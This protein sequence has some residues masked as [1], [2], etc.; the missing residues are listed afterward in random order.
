MVRKVIITTLTGLAA[1]TLAVDLWTRSSGDVL[2]LEGSARLFF[3]FCGPELLQVEFHHAPVPTVDVVKIAKINEW[4]GFGL[5]YF[6]TVPENPD[7]G[8]STTV[9]GPLWM[10]LVLFATYPLVAFARG[11]LR[12]W[13]RARRGGCRKCGYNLTGNVSGRCPECGSPSG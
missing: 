8:G 13:R 11:P 6:H 10:P 1:A 2:E 4:L 9:H 3:S 7:F 12:R 5:Y